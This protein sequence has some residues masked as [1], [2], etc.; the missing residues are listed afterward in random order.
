MKR[1]R[2]AM[3]CIRS[4]YRYSGGANSSECVKKIYIF[5]ITNFI[6]KKEDHGIEQLEFQNG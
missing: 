6:R 4:T 5:R 1:V 3:I 2:K